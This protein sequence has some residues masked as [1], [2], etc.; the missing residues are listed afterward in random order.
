MPK[1]DKNEGNAGSENEES[2]SEE[3][4]L[5]NTVFCAAIPPILMSINIIIGAIFFML[6]TFFLFLY[7]F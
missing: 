1:E 5:A 3:E 7:L 2:G 4:N 6:I